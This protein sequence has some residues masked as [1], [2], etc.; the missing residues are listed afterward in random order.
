MKKLVKYKYEILLGS[1]ILQL[2]GLTF[3]PASFDLVTRKILL[4]QTIL[5]GILLYYNSKKQIYVIILF[6][7]LMLANGYEGFNQDG[8]HIISGILYIIYFTVISVRLYV[9]IFRA[10]AITAEIIS[11]CFAGFILLGLLGSF[12][13]ITIEYFQPQSFSN[14]PLEGAK[15]DDL[16][17][18]SYIT[19]ATVGFGDIAPLTHLAKKTTVLLS[20]V[21]Y[22]YSAFVTSIIIGK[23]I[24]YS[25]EFKGRR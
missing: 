2:M 9:D 4:L 15:F 6:I 3:V 23:Y 21:G 18:Y 24:A 5:P 8:S 25:G 7:S 19:V 13:F 20:L 11:A 12:A 22:F 10:H 16:Q 17:Y 1:L 14:L